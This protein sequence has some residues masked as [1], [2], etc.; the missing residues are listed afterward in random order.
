MSLNK[1]QLEGIKTIPHQKGH[2]IDPNSN[3]VKVRGKMYFK[4]LKE[5]SCKVIIGL[6]KRNLNHEKKE[7][8]ERVNNIIEGRAVRRPITLEVKGKDK[9]ECIMKA[10]ETFRTYM[11]LVGTARLQDIEIPEI[12]EHFKVESNGEAL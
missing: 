4:E 3:K 1:H 2:Y 8:I 9:R 6:A 12:Q 5:N 11:Q 7:D 10:K